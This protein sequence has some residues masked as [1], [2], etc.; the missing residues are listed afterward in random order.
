M[1]ER[2]SSQQQP[3]AAV[4]IKK[5]MIKDSMPNK[6]HKPVSQG[7]KLID[8][9]P[10][11]GMR[12]QSEHT[13]DG[14]FDP[15][16]DGARVETSLKQY[17]ETHLLPQLVALLLHAVLDLGVAAR[18]AENRIRTGVG[19]EQQRK[20]GPHSKVTRPPDSKLEDEG[21]KD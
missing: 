6:G 15:A 12:R 2:A 16:K 13:L 7:D 20:R 10:M 17:S 14:Q 5:H 18:K 4:D 3:S 21:S 1:H 19:S 11:H 9:D 8:N